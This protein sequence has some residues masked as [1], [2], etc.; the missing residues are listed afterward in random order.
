[1]KLLKTGEIKDL[2]KVEALED[3]LSKMGNRIKY[4]LEKINENF[5]RIKNIALIRS[6]MREV[7]DKLDEI[8]ELVY[9]LE[10]EEKNEKS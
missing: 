8:D 2:M 5:Y 9:E 3:N 7:Y 10:L 6:L 4:E 1:L